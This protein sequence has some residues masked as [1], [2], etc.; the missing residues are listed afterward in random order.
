MAAGVCLLPGQAIAQTG[1]AF[2]KNKTIT[3]VVATSPGGGYD[4][5]GRLIARYME[6]GLPGVAVVVKNLPGAGHMIGTNT[7]YAAKP[8]GLTLGTFSTGLVY[9]QISDAPGVKFDLGK[10]SWIGKAASDPHVI[11]TSTKSPYATFD[12]LRLAKVPIRVSAGGV[13]AFAYTEMRMIA[14]AFKLNVNI[15]LGYTG[16]ETEMAMR[17]DEIDANLGSYSSYDAFVR[18]GYGQFVLQ[19]GGTP[20]ASVASARAVAVTADEK[21]TVALIESQTELGRFTAGPPGIPADRL[22]AL[23]HAYRTALENPELQAQ[24]AKSDRPVEPLYG[25][26]VAQ[27]IRAALDQT[28]EMIALVKEIT[29]TAK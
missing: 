10:M 23:R 18:N 2:F 26:E 25:E 6:P 3:Y 8:D 21:A 5:Y 27:R 12:Q 7:I 24:A 29:A 20:P 22:E 15:V 14:R 19:L 13:G 1:A 17:R 11:V 9:A 4:L 28:P 16:N